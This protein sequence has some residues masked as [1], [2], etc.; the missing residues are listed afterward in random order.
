MEACYGGTDVMERSCAVARGKDINRFTGSPFQRNRLLCTGTALCL[1]VVVVKRPKR[2]GYH[3]TVITKRLSRNGYH[4]TV[5]TKWLSRK[6]YYAAVTPPQRPSV[7]ISIP[8]LRMNTETM[9]IYV[10]KQLQ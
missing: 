6:G 7:L 1:V 10:R 3:E 2:N 8:V 5:I 4:E 9:C